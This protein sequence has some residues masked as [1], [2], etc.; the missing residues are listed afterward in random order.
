M[1]PDVAHF[2]WYGRSLHWAQR[3]AIHSALAA[4]GFERAV[5]HH[6]VALEVGPLAKVAGLEL[7]PIEPE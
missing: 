1:I 4:G 7:R 3:V 5:L 6:D 2:I